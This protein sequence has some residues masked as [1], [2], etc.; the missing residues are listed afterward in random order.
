MEPSRIERVKRGAI[1]GGAVG[2]CLGLVLGTWT[3]FKHGPG[4]RG[5]INTLSQFMATS[6]GSFALFMSIGSFI[7]SEEAS[8]NSNS[9]NNNNTL[10]P[11]NLMWKQHLEK[12]RLF[13]SR[14]FA[15]LPVE[16]LERQ[17]WDRSMVGIVKDQDS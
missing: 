14:G 6:A 4:S 5:Y 12:R 13:V 7:R 10:Q 8:N 15:N 16:V 9:G 17:K 1:M 2:L 11:Q 3:I